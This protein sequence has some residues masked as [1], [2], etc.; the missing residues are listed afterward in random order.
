MDLTF[1]I[2][3]LC[4]G[5]ICVLL[6]YITKKAVGN[7]NSKDFDERQ[8]V[9]QGNAYKISFFILILTVGF[10]IISPTLPRG[11]HQLILLFGVVVS[12][13][14]YAVIC[15]IKDAYLSL[16]TKAVQ[17]VVALYLLGAILLFPV[18]SSLVISAIDG[19]FGIEVCYQ[20]GEVLNPL[21][22]E[23]MVGVMMFTVA[24]VQLVKYLSDKKHLED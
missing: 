18:V 5:V 4:A 2:M 17:K 16:S 12:I 14:A 24:T 6:G 8:K 1:V 13:T 23:G 10:E 11:Y 20:D 9:I 3:I 19:N 7:T 22:F 15:I 21:I